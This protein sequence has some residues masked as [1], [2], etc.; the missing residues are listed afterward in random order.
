MR[1]EYF[2]DGAL[3][4]AAGFLF[5]W[6]VPLI[7]F[8]GNWGLIG[9]DTVQSLF[10][11]LAPDP[12]SVLSVL[13]IFYIVI[14]SAMFFIYREL[15]FYKKRHGHGVDPFLFALGAFLIGAVLGYGAVLFL[16]LFAFHAAGGVSL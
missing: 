6:L 5:F 16:G 13:C 3:G 2:L 8:H 4:F 15:P 7:A 11:W 1:K 10:P 14:D 9:Y 12:Q